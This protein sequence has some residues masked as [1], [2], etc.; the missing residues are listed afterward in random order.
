MCH[1]SH[2][3]RLQG[4]PSFYLE[5]K[6]IIPSICHTRRPISADYMMELSNRTI[7]EKKQPPSGEWASAR[8]KAGAERA[9]WKIQQQ[10]LERWVGGL[11]NR[12]WNSFQSWDFSVWNYWIKTTKCRESFFMHF[13]NPHGV[14][15][16]CYNNQTQAYFLKIRWNSHETFLATGAAG[17][18]LVPWLGIEPTPP[19]L[20][21]WSLNH[22]TTREVP[23]SHF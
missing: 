14:M 13:L 20:E 7:Q 3:R 17:E 21:A 4:W 23:T 8:V 19:P 12:C 10:E 22:W 11:V 9:K 16:L 18:I 1:E 15:V 5:M 2:P 6:F